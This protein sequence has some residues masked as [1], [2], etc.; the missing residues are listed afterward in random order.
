VRIQAYFGVIGSHENV[1]YVARHAN[2]QTAVVKELG[3]RRPR[4]HKLIEQAR[5]IWRTERT[6]V[7][8]AEIE[9]QLEQIVLGLLKLPVEW[10]SAIADAE[11]RVFTL[12]V[13]TE[14][15]ETP[16][17]ISLSTLSVNA[18]SILGAAFDI[19]HVTQM[20]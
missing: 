12:I 7:N 14:E 17:S 8:P 6:P 13:Q 10:K 19:D 11:E 18:L 15:G 5:W 3:T 20:D 16:S 1:Q 2:L 9:T 4:S